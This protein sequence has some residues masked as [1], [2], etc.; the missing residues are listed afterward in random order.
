MRI[1]AGTYG[2]RKLHPVPGNKTRPTTD[3]VRESIFNMIG[4][5]F[6]GGNFLD[7]FA[8]SGAVALEALSRGMQRAVLVDRQFAAIKTIKQ[9]ATIVTDPDQTVTVWKMSAEK[10]L[11]TLTQQNEQF[12][13]IF[14]DPPYAAQQMNR[15][16]AEI[17]ELRL[18]RPR[19]LVICETDHTAELKEV[20]H[21][22]LLRQKDYGLTLVT[23]YQGKE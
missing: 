15:Q 16:L 23:I 22:E 6:Q 18:L 9:N 3:K 2:G 11:Q 1:I 19:G 21:Y 7:L 12:D 10:A 20:E 17:W 5:Y 14:L 4:P 13:V 8:G